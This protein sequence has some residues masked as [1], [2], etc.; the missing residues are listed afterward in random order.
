MVFKFRGVRLSA[1]LGLLLAVMLP[2][3]PA[4][5]HAGL[6]G[7][8]PA[9]S[10]V[11]AAAPSEI[12]LFFDEP[13]DVVFGSIR[14]L[15]AQ[16]EEVAAGRPQ[17]DDDNSSIARLPLPTLPESAYIVVWRVTSSDSHP[18]QGSFEFQIGTAVS[19]LSDAATVAASAAAESHGL[20]TLFL[21]I[22][23][24]TFMGIVVLVGGCALLTKF[25]RLPISVRTSSLLL[26]A[27]LFA[28]F[29]TLQSLIAYGPHVSGLKIWEARRLSL[30]QDTLTTHFGR[31]Q[32]VRIAALIVLAV[33]LRSSRWRV[34]RGYT[35]LVWLSIVVAIG[36]ISFSGHAYSQSPLALSVALDM[37]H[38]ATIGFWVGSVVLFAIDRRGWLSGD[39]QSTQAV[40]WFSR[41][42]G[43][44]VP[45]MVATGVAQAWIMMQGISGVTDTQ[46]GR[47]LIVKTSLV[48]V[49]VAIGGV[50][51]K[52]LRRS[53]PKSLQQTLSIEAILIAVIIAI[54]ASLVA[55]P[56]RSVSSLEPFA[57]TLVRQDVLVNI[58]VTPT[59]VGNSEV[60]IIIT[61][62]GGSLQQMQS[63]TARV[64]LPAG[65]I[66]TGPLALEK[67]GS[68]HFVA[69][70]RFAFEGTWKLE[71]LVV[72][73]ANTTLLYSTDV[74]I[75]N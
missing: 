68:N 46:Y 53:G 27:W 48:V 72:P 14:V 75:E 23:W 21:F 26:G 58:T 61:P 35:M 44:A 4:S 57:T 64:A 55:L 32:L 36:T 33:V 15:D 50:A 70:Y 1:L 71:V 20:S 59:R 38:F 6:E 66:P 9:P 7:S 73:K 11:L 56:P 43:F 34:S 29:A 74:E 31:M 42:A 8:E 49:V 65:N 18:V 60:H 37:V 67:I 19:P 62:P 52:A 63:V 24:V 40:N 45:V 5:A 2:A 16:G 13:I 69:N 25:N 22:R 3:M 51:R 12:A 10:S 54:T 47:T 28:F 41:V 30:L 17:R 39:E